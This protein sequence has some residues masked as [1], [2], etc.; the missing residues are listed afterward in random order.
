M[1]C[2]LNFLDLFMVILFYDNYKV[3][4]DKGINL[5]DFPLSFYFLPDNS[6]KLSLNIIASTIKRLETVK[7]VKRF[8]IYSH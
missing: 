1:G 7:T 8:A 2:P 5:Y 6:D 4:Q 3:N